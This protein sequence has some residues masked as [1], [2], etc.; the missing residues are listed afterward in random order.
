MPISLKAASGGG[1]MPLGSLMVAPSVINYDYTEDGI[2]YLKTGFVETDTSK[3]DNT[4]FNYTVG[5]LFTNKRRVAVGA[6]S[7]NSAVT[8]SADNGVGTIVMTRGN[9]DPTI[10]NGLSS[11][12]DSGVT[13][14]TLGIGNIQFWKVIWVQTLSLFVAVAGGDSAVGLGELIYTSLDGVNWTTRHSSTSAQRITSVAFGNG[15]L[16]AVSSDGTRILRSTNG[17]TWN[18]ITPAVT[19]VNP[20]AV[21]YGN[22]KFIISGRS[23]YCQVS[24]DLGLTWSRLDLSATFTADATGTAIHFADNKFV[25]IFNKNSSNTKTIATSVDGVSWDSI[26]ANL[27]PSA[28]AIVGWLRYNQG[29][30]FYSEASSIASR[31][32]NL[33]S[34][35]GVGTFFG[36][37]G[38][39][40]QIIY[41]LNK[42]FCVSYTLNASNITATYISDG[43]SLPYAGS[44]AE[45]YAYTGGSGQM[46]VAYFMRVY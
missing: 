11:S 27:S 21:A 16:V 29:V 44:P 12:I 18:V 6:A 41:N 36:S 7:E 31:S 33:I 39:S 24:T 40:P 8:S 10:Y 28:S 46:P 1:K 43:N 5:T 32:S 15:V 37:I 26:S 4:F 19:T 42:W 22:G 17:T 34:W 30:W 25:M 14:T 35:S 23:D 2:R 45:Q 9:S 3:F 13:W 20:R 38:E